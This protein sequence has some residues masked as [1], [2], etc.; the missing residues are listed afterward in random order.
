MLGLAAAIAN[1]N[2]HASGRRRLRYLPIRIEDVLTSWSGVR[3][4]A[5]LRFAA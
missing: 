2:H 4:E 5:F 1:A 3:Y